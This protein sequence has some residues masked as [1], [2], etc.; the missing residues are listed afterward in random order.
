[1]VLLSSLDSLSENKNQPGSTGP[2]VEVG[3]AGGTIGSNRT[4]FEAAYGMAVILP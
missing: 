4:C 1:M 2:S 3:R